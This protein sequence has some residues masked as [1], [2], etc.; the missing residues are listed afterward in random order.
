VWWWR[1]SPY[2]GG[3]DSIGRPAVV[4][5]ILALSDTHLEFPTVADLPD[6]DVVVHAGDWTDV[7]FRHSSRFDL[8]SDS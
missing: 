6:A 7:G 5:K 8:L 1:V 3:D 2:L 4:M